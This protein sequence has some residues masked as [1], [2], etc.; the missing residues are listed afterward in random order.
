VAKALAKR[1][2][3]RYQNI[4]DLLVDLRSLES[5]PGLA[6]ARDRGRQ[7]RR[8]WIGAAALAL[9]LVIAA[10]AWRFGFSSRTPDPGDLGLAVLPFVNTGGNAEMEYLSDGISESILGALSALPYLKV[11]SCSSVQRFRGPKADPLEAGHRLGVQAVLVGRVVQRGESVSVYSELIDVKDNRQLWGGQHHGKLDQ[12]VNLQSRIGQD[13][14]TA[15]SSRLGGRHQG[16]VSQPHTSSD[17][18]YQSYLKGRY[19]WYRRTG[20]TLRTAIQH[21]QQA[22]EK[23]PAFALAHAGLAD[24][25]AVISSYTT[26]PP[27]D[28][29][30]KATAAAEAALALNPRVAETHTALGV[31][32]F[33]LDW[34]W[35]GGEEAMRSALRISP[36]YAIAH[37]W[38]SHYLTCMER[39]PEALSEIRS[40]QQNDPCLPWEVLWLGCTTTWRAN[41]TNPS[42]SYGRCLRWIPASDLAAARSDAH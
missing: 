2:D 24:C 28:S 17:E 27:R 41:M 36:G 5:H 29:L 11:M 42:A 7:P 40:A 6:K 31:V 21:F 10:L 22:I 25:Y 33:I 1:A 20:A 39:F 38:Y 19:L 12:I 3:E 35:T 32:K 37:Q 18:A 15:L 30:S 34:D 8:Q 9:M 14:A 23:D 4:A 13:I 16:I 26:I